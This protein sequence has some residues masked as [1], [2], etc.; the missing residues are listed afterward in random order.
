MYLGGPRRVE[1]RWPLAERVDASVAQLGIGQ[2]T[3]GESRICWT[4]AGDHTLVA[5]LEPTRRSPSFGGEVDATALVVS[6]TETAPPFT[7]VTS[8]LGSA[9]AVPV[10][11]AN[12]ETVE[13]TL[14]DG[15]GLRGVRVTFQP[16]HAPRVAEDDTPHVSTVERAATAQA[17][18]SDE[19]T[20]V[21][22]GMVERA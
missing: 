12:G 18:G 6:A 16:G 20:R 17:A 13:L 14:P 2:L 10:L 22:S 4:T 19:S 9:G 21:T 8:F 1:L 3:L 15:S 7:V 11:K 5:A